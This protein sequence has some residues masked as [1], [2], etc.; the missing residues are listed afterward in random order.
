LR[1]VLAKRE[2][3]LDLLEQQRALSPATLGIERRADLSAEEF[4]ERYYSTNRPVILTGQLRGWPAL[5]AWTPDYLK[6]RL[7]DRDVELQGGRRRDPN[8]EMYK[9]AHRRREPFSDFIDRICQPG[10]GNDAYI[11]AYNSTQN[12]EALSV[13]SADLGDLDDFLVRPA[14]G[15]FEMFWIGPAGTFTPLHHDL[16]NNFVAQI[17]GR[18]SF[19]LLP[20][21]ETGKLYNKHY[22]FSEVTDLE[23][24]RLDIDRFDHLTRVRIYDLMLNPGEILFI[25]VG[26]WHQVRSLDFSVS[27]TYT[28]FLWDNDGGRSYPGD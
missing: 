1:Q 11:T 25:P 27:I 26:W 15:P 3:L 12:V 7:G 28:S 24:P 13:L 10:A 17:T 23:D 21:S 2:W 18:K 22:V 9:D 5:E 4:L 6:A 19:K 14:A 8:F 20:P 16:T